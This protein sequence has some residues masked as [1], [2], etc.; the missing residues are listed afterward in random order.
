M[1]NVI[2]LMFKSQADVNLKI[3]LTCV[4]M[5][6]KTTLYLRFKLCTLT[7]K[8]CWHVCTWVMNNFRLHVQAD[9]NLMLVCVHM[10]KVQA[11]ISSKCWHVCTCTMNNFRLNVQADIN[12]MLACVMNTKT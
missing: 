11:H 5:D 2:D 7:L 4:C 6:D 1:N 8:Q 10:D 9:V 3:L 12:S